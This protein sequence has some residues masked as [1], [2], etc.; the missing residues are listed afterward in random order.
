MSH[1]GE[2]GEHWLSISDMM[3]GLMV[4]FL[5]IAITYMMQV[6][7]DRNQLVEIAVTYEK[8]KI[9]IYNELQIEF[10]D[11]LK[12]WNAEIDKDSLAIR[13]QE[14]DILFDVG[15]A[16][17]KTKFKNILEHKIN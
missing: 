9:A 6:S 7:E 13:F 17:I 10:R 5:F 11:D 3:S 15:D 2:D 1:N 16:V 12:K 4:I 14:P 8:T